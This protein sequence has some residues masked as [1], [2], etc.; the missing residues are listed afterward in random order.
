MGSAAIV[1]ATGV[2]IRTAT[3]ASGMISS[4]LSRICRTPDD[5]RMA[6]SGATG[7]GV[8]HGD[9]RPGRI[10]G[11]VDGQKHTRREPQSEPGTPVSFTFN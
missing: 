9:Y 5:D 1:G 11:V 10:G 3:V 4:R 2:G 6:A 7:G 8:H